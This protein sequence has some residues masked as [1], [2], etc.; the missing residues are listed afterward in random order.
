MKNRNT[1]GQ[2]I[3]DACKSIRDL[4]YKIPFSWSNKNFTKK[5]DTKCH[6]TL[7]LPWL[8]IFLRFD[9]CNLGKAIYR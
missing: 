6:M 7:K 8:P 3:T 4:V 1:I 5:I 2:I 9:L